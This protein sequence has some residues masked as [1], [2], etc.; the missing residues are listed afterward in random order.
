MAK[1]TG[2]EGTLEVLRAFGSLEKELTSLT[3]LPLSISGI[4]G[5]SPVFRYTEVFPPLPAIF[6]PAD[7]SL[8]ARTKNHYLM[9]NENSS[10]RVPNY[11]PHIEASVQLAMSGKWPDE[12][13]AVRKTKAAF[14]IQIAE[15]LRTQC[16][17]IAQANSHWVDVLKDGFVFR[18]E[19]AHQK[20]V[21]LLKR[22]ISEDRIRKYRDNEESIELE[23]RLF[24][25][26]KLSSALHGYVNSFYQMFL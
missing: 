11:V 23:K 10:K 17:L 18:L 15:C 13:E 24:H 19:V 25:L 1:G 6:D 14:H 22:E 26:P 20:E 7:D 2:E 12:L 16:Q 4:K 9:I 5:C 8:V 21:A 3:D